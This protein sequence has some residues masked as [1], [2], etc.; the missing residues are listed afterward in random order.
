[1]VTYRGLRYVTGDQAIEG[2]PEDMHG[3]RF[4]AALCR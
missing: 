3:V 4:R 1:M 2:A